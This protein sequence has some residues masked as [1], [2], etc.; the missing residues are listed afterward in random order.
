[1]YFRDFTAAMAAITGRGRKSLEKARRQTVMVQLFLKFP[2]QS[3][4]GVVR[5]QVHGLSPGKGEACQC[6]NQCA[7]ASFIANHRVLGAVI[8]RHVQYIRHIFQIIFQHIRL[9]QAHPSAVE[10]DAHPASGFM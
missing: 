6:G 8:D 7:A 10:M 4:G 5:H 2:V 9:M 3:P 1:M